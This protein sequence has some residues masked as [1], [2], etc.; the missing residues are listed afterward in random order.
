MGLGGLEDRVLSSP[1]PSIGPD[2][3]QYRE[4]FVGWD[5]ETG[6]ERVWGGSSK[7]PAVQSWFCLRLAV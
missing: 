5:E 7:R 4:T 2:W 1:L 3:S 6:Q